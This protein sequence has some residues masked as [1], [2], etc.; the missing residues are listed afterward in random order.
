MRVLLITPKT[1]YPDPQLSLDMIPQ[2]PA[3]ISGTLKANGH[4]VF[5]VNT[6]HDYS[7]D[8]A[9]KVLKRHIRK[10]IKDYEPEVIATGAMAAE[11]LFLQ[12]AI[13]ISRKEAPHLPVICGGGIIT[14]DPLSHE[15]LRPDFS[16]IDEGE[17]VITDL[18]DKLAHGEDVTEVEGIHYWKEGKPVYGHARKAIKDL[19]SLPFPDYDVMDIETYFALQSQSTSYFHV[20]T[21]ENPRMLPI[22]SG[23]SCPYKCTFCQYA[24]LGGSRRIYRGRTIENVVEEII[25][26]HEKYGFNILKI[27]DD[28]FSVKEERVYKFC[29]EIKK[30]GLDIHWNASMRV[31]DV[32][33]DMLKEMK[34]AGCIH[35][36]YGFESASNKVLESMNKRITDKDILKAIEMT[37]AA[38][39]GAQGNFIFG[40]PAETEETVIKTKDFYRKYCLDHIIHND[41]L[42]PYPGSPVFDYCT[43]KGII[44]DRKT[45]YKSIHLRPVYNMTNMPEKKFLKLVKPAVDS[46][47]EGIRFAINVRFSKVSRKGFEHS[48]FDDHIL[49][50]VNATCPHCEKDIN[51]VF[52]THNREFTRKLNSFIYPVRYFCHHCHKRILISRLSLTGQEDSYLDYFESIKELANLKKPVVVLPLVDPKMFEAFKA[53]GVKTDELDIRCFMSFEQVQD[54]IEFLEHK[55]VSFSDDEILRNIDFDFVVLPVNGDQKIKDMLLDHN[56]DHDRIHVMPGC[57]N[58]KPNWFLDKNYLVLDLRNRLRYYS[59]TIIKYLRIQFG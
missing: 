25:F 49:L 7:G 51:Y 26:Q 2:G 13:D 45:Y 55:V 17:N 5:G 24:S 41:Y 34:D 10:A 27:Y 35:I 3:Y 4:D 46:F 28:L 44:K 38:G 54:G 30:T 50:K 12:D 43:N 33:P 16:V 1:N 21:R 29:E 39:I 9:R 14:N 32:S 53:Y 23:R 52:P 15:I 6:S 19:D 20:R 18:L 42:M 57:Q 11:F 8:P 56:V 40:D 31:H 59:R 58:S 22:S 48:Y 36:G 37:E 47:L